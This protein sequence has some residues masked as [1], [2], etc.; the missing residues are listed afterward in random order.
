MRSAG[1]YVHFT[2]NQFYK[3]LDALKT[4]KYPISAGRYRAEPIETIA[5]RRP[6]PGSPGTDRSSRMQNGLSP[7]YP[8]ALRETF[9]FQN[10]R[11]ATRRYAIDELVKEQWGRALHDP[12]VRAVI[13]ASQVMMAVP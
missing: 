10:R 1:T 9:E 2:I 11:I 7:L 3:Y 8:D 12:R 6:C 4:C 13:A 5:A